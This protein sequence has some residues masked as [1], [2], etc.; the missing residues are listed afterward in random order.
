[1][2]KGKLENAKTMKNTKRIEAKILKLPV[3][4]ALEARLYFKR[5]PEQLIGVQKSLIKSI[6]DLPLFAAA[7]E[8]AQKDLFE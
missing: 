2:L 7:N 3:A 1:L 8:A 5:H 4:E 6:N